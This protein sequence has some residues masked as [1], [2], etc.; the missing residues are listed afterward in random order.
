M[1]VL[2]EFPICKIPGCRN[3]WDGTH[4]SRKCAQCVLERKKSIEDIDPV[5]VEFS[6]NFE[7]IQQNCRTEIKFANNGTLYT[8]KC[9]SEYF[10]GWILQTDDRSINVIAIHQDDL[11]PMKKFLKTID[12]K[13][14]PLEKQWITLPF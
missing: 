14:Y 4:P 13:Y 10:N 5:R 2:V 3:R 12:E 9:W 6:D 11:I 7:L 1:E 8:L